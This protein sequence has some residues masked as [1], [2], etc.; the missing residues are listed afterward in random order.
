[1]RDGKTLRNES[2]HCEGRQAVFISV[3]VA[4]EVMVILK[5]SNDDSACT[6]PSAKDILSVLLKKNPNCDTTIIFIH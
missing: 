4:D 5:C 2:G 1:V 6:R 3:P